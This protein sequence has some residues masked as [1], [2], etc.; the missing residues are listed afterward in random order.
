[1]VTTGTTDIR[2]AAARNNSDWCAA[3]CRSHGIPTTFGE[4]AWHS[5]RRTPPYYPDA[6]TL[7]HDAVPTD[8]LPEIDTRSPGC[9]IKDSFA[10]LDLSTDGF[11]ELFAAQWIHRPAGLPV[12]AAPALRTEQISTAARL[13]DWQIAWSGGDETLDV[14]RPALLDDP[15]VLVFAGYDGKDLAG[16]FALNGSASVVGLSNLFAVDG[17]EVAGIW[18]SALAAAAQHFPGLPVVGYEHGDDL[19]PA[20]DSG[21]TVLGPLRVWM[22]RS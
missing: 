1:M 3:V 11:V 22:H 18:S 6:I 16:G 14:F 8:F 7:L 12:P 4:M 9:S 19:R 21:F 5:A 10:A 20:L 17:G 13:R 2:T 15:A